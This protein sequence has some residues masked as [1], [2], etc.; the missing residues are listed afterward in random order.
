MER[1]NGDITSTSVATFICI[2][3]YNCRPA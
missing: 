1:E 2:S 3:D